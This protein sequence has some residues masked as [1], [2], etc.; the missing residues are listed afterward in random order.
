MVVTRGNNKTDKN[1]ATPT[2][3]QSGRKAKNK[4]GS[5][6]PGGTYPYDID[7]DSDEYNYADE[8]ESGSEHKPQSDVESASSQREK[9]SINLLQQL[10]IDIQARGG[11]QNFSLTGQQVLRTICDQRPELFG[12]KGDKLRERI[13]KKVNRWKRL[14]E[15]DYINHLRD[16]LRLTDQQIKPSSSA[17][18]DKKPPAKVITHSSNNNKVPSTVSVPSSSIQ[19]VTSFVGCLDSFSDIKNASMSTMHNTSKSLLR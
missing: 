2:K 17:E 16:T 18:E 1:K 19:S 8:N 5:P 12:Q 13:G 15:I 9:L 10:A 14:S 4:V 7:E 11:I 6:A 3:S